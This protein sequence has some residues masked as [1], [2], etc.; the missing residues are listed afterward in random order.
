MSNDSMLE[1][2]ENVKK[3]RK[4]VKKF[5]T[6]N[7][8]SDTMY[9]DSF[10]GEL[11]IPYSTQGRFSVPDE[12]T[13]RDYTV[14]D[15]TTLSI[16]SED[17][18]LENIVSILNGLNSNGVKVEDM[19]Y[20]EFV[21]TLI[22]MKAKFNTS[23]HL[24]SWYCD[25]QQGIPD[26][27]KMECETTVDLKKLN[28]VSVLEADKKLQKYYKEIFDN[29]SDEE[30]ASYIKTRYEFSDKDVDENWTK[31]QELKTISIKEP[32]DIAIG[33]DIFT[34]S[35]IRIGHVLEAH[36]RANRKHNGSMKKIQN[37]KLKDTP[38]AEIKAIKAEKVEALKKLIAKDTTVIASALSL[39]EKNGK[40]LSVDDRISEWRKFPRS[41][42]MQLSSFIEL[43]KTGLDSE[44]DMTCSLCGKTTRRSL[45]DSFTPIELLPIQSN[46]KRT[47][48][49][50]SRPNIYIRA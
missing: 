27:D 19:L 2:P 3:R 5:D 46:T 33:E 34:F 47:S 8:V 49:Q 35:Q 18:I 36:K 10:I 39:I 48:K 13:W 50:H 38:L 45:Q 15:V 25:C 40:P 37:E 29:F 4:P 6:E 21:E 1:N 17:D 14:D 31:E 22:Y 11:T 44:L 26:T 9:L 7:I 24:H 16:S 12:L 32:I 30:F 43:M 42:M 23:S 20:E 41:G 28:F